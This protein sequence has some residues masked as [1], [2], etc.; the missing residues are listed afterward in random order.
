[1]SGSGDRVKETAKKV[2]FAA[3][4][5]RPGGWLFTH[6]L[7]RID[8]PLM[9]L[10]KGRA[11][12]GMTMPHVVLTTTGARSGKSRSVPLLYT[13]DGAAFVL[14][15]SNGGSNHHP[16]W[17]HNLVANRSATV[18]IDGMAIACTG[19]EA[20]GPERERLWVGAT[21]SYPGYEAYQKR[22]SRPIPVMVLEPD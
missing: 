9:R 12:I 13:R 3:S 1:M 10:S 2:L 16:G 22:A 20:E 21:A 7:Y 14:I 4:S 18:E 15:A 19:R 8:L 17:Y 11:R 5:S 6:V